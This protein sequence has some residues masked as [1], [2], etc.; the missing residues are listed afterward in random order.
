MS[1][2]VIVMI[3]YIGLMLFIAVYATKRH[4][5]GLAGNYFFAD[6]QLPL[7]LAVCMLAGNGIGGTA[8]I[9][10]AEWAYGYG[11]SAIW[12][13]IFWG[14]GVAV[15]GM[16]IISQIKKL[17][18]NTVPELIAR[19]F[20]QRAAL[21]TT[22]LQLFILL[23]LTASQYVAGAAVLN[24]LYPELFTERI[25]MLITAAVFITITF[26][27]GYR[28]ISATNIINI[29][30]IYIGAFM[31]LFAIQSYGGMEEITARLPQDGDWMHPINGVG[32]PL[33]L[34][35]LLAS[36]MGKMGNQ[37]II[38]TVR[39]SKNP[40]AARNSFILAG[41]VVAPVGVL[42]TFYGLIAKAYYPDLASAALALPV[43]VKT[44]NPL[45]GGV[46][47]AGLWAATIST[48]S[49]TLISSAT[50]V[51]NDILDHTLKMSFS[52]RMRAWLPRIMVLIVAVVTF[53]VAARI[54]SL[55]EFGIQCISL[56]TPFTFIIFAILYCP[57]ILRKSTAS[58]MI[59]ISI[60]IQILW[61]FFPA[62]RLV[63]GVI[64]Y[65]II[66]G[67]LVLVLTC[68]LDKRRIS[69]E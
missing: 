20:G 63:P 10:V 1:T 11:L 22:L 24:G 4:K 8:T 29:V 32:W 45:I 57:R 17:N 36:L 7:L 62:T 40:K 39:A 46:V 42:M 55:L 6:G 13:T 23:M 26:V 44:L 27:G 16:L 9:G 68:L 25:A 52:E 43:V 49:S 67:L 35:W 15:I 65:H 31:V 21:L 56:M 64:Y 38:Q 47:L 61:I 2:I 58:L 41:L 12:F 14:I 30:V 18:I 59:G 51:V 48:A 53:F 3:A 54:E 37:S 34:T 66:A 28:G 5:S 50:L 19:I 33:V 69:T 60:V